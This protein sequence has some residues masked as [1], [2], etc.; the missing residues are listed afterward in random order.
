[1]K[2]IIPREVIA[3]I[4]TH[5]CTKEDFSGF[6]QSINSKGDTPELS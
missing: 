3:A 4:K 2:H 6:F 5:F 1:M